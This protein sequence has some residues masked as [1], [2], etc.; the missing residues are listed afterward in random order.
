MNITKERRLLKSKNAHVS[1]FV[2]AF[3]S[4]YLKCISNGSGL[5]ETQFGN[6]VNATVLL[7]LVGKFRFQFTPS[8]S[9]SLVVHQ[10]EKRKLISDNIRLK[11]HAPITNT[12]DSIRKQQNLNACMRVYTGTCTHTLADKLRHVPTYSLGE[13][14]HALFYFF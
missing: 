3:V 13:I 5:I 11:A 4:F 10:N 14:T 6:V 7:V 2:V 12:Q 1:F 8:I 9:N